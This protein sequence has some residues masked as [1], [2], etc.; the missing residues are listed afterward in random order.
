M[1]D[2]DTYYALQSTFESIGSDLSA[3][4]PCTVVSREPSGCINV[5]FASP[6]ADV[7]H[8]VYGALEFASSSASLKPVSRIVVG[9][10]L[11]AGST[12]RL[13]LDS[14]FSIRVPAE[15]D[16]MKV[17]VGHLKNVRV[18]VDIISSDTAD[19]ASTVPHILIVPRSVSI[20]S[21][22]HGAGHARRKEVLNADNPMLSSVTARRW[23]CELRGVRAV[24]NA[25]DKLCIY[26]MACA[27]MAI[28]IQSYV[29][30]AKA[31][32]IADNMGFEIE[33]IEWSDAK[34]MDGKA[35]TAAGFTIAPLAHAMG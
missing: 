22:T 26:K 29:S 5:E 10:S 30:G 2:L 3:D 16:A 1:L 32:T 6:V 23:E 21:R 4:L 7:S 25:E 27:V 20:S 31:Q 33:Y 14:P 24:K 35:V 34:G 28:L 8:I 17:T 18:S 12:W 19:R 11:V 13:K 9:A 15:G